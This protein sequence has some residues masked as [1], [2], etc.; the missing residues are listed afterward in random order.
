MKWINE[1]RLKGTS[2]WTADC[3]K[4]SAYGWKQIL[5]LRD[6]M[7]IHIRS[8][9][10]N[11][12][13]TFFWHD[14]W[15]GPEPLSSYIPMEAVT[16]AGLDLNVKLKDMIQGGQWTW[17]VEWSDR[18]PIIQTIPIPNLQDEP[19]DKYLWCPSNERCTNYSASRVWNEWR[20]NGNKVEWSDLIWFSNCTPKHSFIMWIAMHGR[21]TTQDRLLKWYPDRQMACS[22]CEVCLD[23]INHL[24]FE[25]PYSKRIWSEFKKK[26]E[27]TTLPDIWDDIVSH[28]ISQKFNKSIRSILR[29][30]GL[31]ACVYFIWN[32]R[33]KRMFTNE[34]N[35]VDVFTTIVN[36]LR[37]KLS[38]LHVKDSIQVAEICKKWKVVMNIKKG[39][40]QLLPNIT[41]DTV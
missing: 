3:D 16:Q 31:A 26:I 39:D 10:G 21:L 4:N 24:F 8:K 7:R 9:V 41:S 40:E 36:Y 12:K 34:K 25:C 13:S 20:P 19:I 33:N 22:L 37:L 29:R 27:Q 28:M 23:S 17:P 32:E 14:R 38:S 15:W 11:G 5:K 6:Q 2:V 1:V 35:D 30:V 18:F